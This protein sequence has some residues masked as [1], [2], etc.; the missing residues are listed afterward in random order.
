MSIQLVGSGLRESGIAGVLPEQRETAAPTSRPAY[1]GD[2]H[3]WLE[4]PVLSR[5]D[6]GAARAGPLVIEEYDATCVVPPGAQAEV[7]AA[8]NLVIRL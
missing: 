8:G 1:F 3:G 7:D 5:A 6:L 2:E 4:T